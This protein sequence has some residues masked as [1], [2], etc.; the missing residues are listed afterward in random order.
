MYRVFIITT[1]ILN[2]CKFQT[3]VQDPSLINNININNINPILINH[4]NAF[5]KC[6]GTTNLFSDCAVKIFECKID[7]YE[8][9]I[10][11]IC[12]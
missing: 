3:W 5:S 2:F 10:Q 7:T 12:L 11:N 8:I 4:K 9:C 6:L 1:E